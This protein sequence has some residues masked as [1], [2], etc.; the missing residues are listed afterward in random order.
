[1]RAKAELVPNRTDPWC[2]ISSARLL[3]V[4]N[5][6][7]S[8]ST[9]YYSAEDSD[10]TLAF[11]LCPPIVV[12]ISVDVHPLPVKQ[13]SGANF[14]NVH[15]VEPSGALEQLVCAMSDGEGSQQDRNAIIYSEREY[16]MLV[17]PT[18]E[19]SELND[20]TQVHKMLRTLVDSHLTHSMGLKNLQKREI[21]FSDMFVSQ[22]STLKSDRPED[23][24]K[25]FILN[26]TYENQQIYY[27]CLRH[28]LIEFCP[29]SAIAIYLFLRFHIGDE[30]GS[31][32]LYDFNETKILKGNN[33]LANISYSQQHKSSLRVLELSQLDA[34]KVNLNKLICNTDS[35]AKPTLNDLHSFDWDVLYQRAGFRSK[36]SKESLHRQSI[37]D[38]PQDVLA[39]IFPFLKPED[40][41]N[42]KYAL[43]FLKV[44]L[45]QDMLYIKKKYPNHPLSLH[46]IFNSETFLSFAAE[47][48]AFVRD[49]FTTSL[50][51]LEKGDV[52]HHTQSFYTSGSG[53]DVGFIR[54]ELGQLLEDQTKLSDLQTLYIK[55][56]RNSVNGLSIL[57]SLGT[58]HGGIIR[59][60]LP[61]IIHTLDLIEANGPAASIENIR[62]SLT[63]VTMLANTKRSSS[64]ESQ[65]G[66]L[67]IM[68]NDE[69]FDPGSNSIKG[70]ASALHQ[71]PMGFSS[72][73]SRTAS[74]VNI[75]SDGQSDGHVKLI[76]RG[77]SLTSNT[78]GNSLSLESRIASAPSHRIS[79]D[80][81]KR[82]RVLRRRLSRQ[83]TTLY[84]MWD[85]FKSLE[86]ELRDNDI[87][88]TEWLKTHG[89]SERQFRHT[90]MKIIKFIEEEAEKRDVPVETIKE[91]L[92]TKMRNRQRPWTLDEVQRRLTAFKTIQLDE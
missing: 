20:P 46:P 42:F 9:P 67:N 89:S 77:N 50:Y 66:S 4:S 49:S 62:N 56:L 17:R 1:M 76:L 79:K 86:K 70:S 2:I 43:D 6:I 68:S 58:T 23:Q 47:R 5:G 48:E 10:T 30:Y 51:F 16:Y 59:Q 82:D 53:P 60:N 21:R 87:S 54:A 41:S 71:L 12:P 65:D 92:Q 45:V 74:E 44:S 27:G 72:S 90:R 15:I 69:A 29:I 3:S 83:A 64:I 18:W 91:K 33:K 24:S 14:L 25:V 78:Q 84:E 37:I 13:P 57:A 8:N 31:I 88:V 7:E 80:Q 75:A 52:D 85:D 11:A 36:N 63:K 38:I 61:D 81:T 19:S 39:E 55:N 32:E 73:S 28:R 26:T 35:S 40:T 34:S 22:T